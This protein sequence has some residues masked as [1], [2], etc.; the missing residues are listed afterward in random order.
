MGASERPSLPRARVR[1][2]LLVAAVALVVVVGAWVG[3][4]VQQPAA[5]RIG[6]VAS[7]V[8]DVTATVAGGKVEAASGLILT[9]AGIM[10]TNYHV[11]DGASDIAVRVPARD[12]AFNAS[13][14]ALDPSDDIGVLQVQ[15]AADLPI[16]SLDGSAPVA[17]GSHVVAIGASHGDGTVRTETEATV[18][19]VDQSV[20]FV[21]PVTG[22]TVTLAGVISLN[23]ALQA[24]DAGG[25]LVSGSGAVVGM[26]GLGFAIPIHTV[27]EIAR[28][29][30]TG[31][32]NP[33]LLR[34]HSVVL[35]VAVRD[36]VS[37]PGARVSVVDAA[38]PAQAV[39][40][41]DGDVVTGVGGAAV[42]SAADL[43]R[44]LLGHHAGEQVEVRWMAAG[45]RPR[46]A[47]VWLA[48]GTSD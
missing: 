26:D 36:S 30:I 4:A 40:I 11:I 31:S 39:G 8:A 47:Q 23:A 21:D 34:G 10:V 42:A 35:G 22:R 29:V 46:R 2:L 45:S 33:R 28:D 48:S 37:P 7:G 17:V 24:A 27:A 38:S 13:I 6:A 44:L 16:V 12:A 43:Q 41:R 15:Q 25:P 3:A 14:V 32:A 20:G 1:G 9:P 19:A 5:D 18:S